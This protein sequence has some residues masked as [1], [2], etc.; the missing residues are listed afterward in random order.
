MKLLNF[1]D[2]YDNLPY[3]LRDEV[4]AKIKE[5]CFLE[6]DVQFYNRKKGASRIR[7]YEKNRIVEIFA[8]Y[9]ID[10]YTGCETKK[11]TVKA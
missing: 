2:A 7:E 4:K 3:G 6:S 10:A 5:A 1:E 11:V 9:G 8:K